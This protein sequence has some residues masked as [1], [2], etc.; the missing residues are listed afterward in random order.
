MGEHASPT[1]LYLS[2]MIEQSPL[3]TAVLDPDG[4]YLLVNSSW[5]ELWA[6]GVGGPSEEP[7]VFENERFMAMGL[8]PYLEACRRN[9]EI[10]TPLLFRE[11]TLAVWS[12]WLRAFIYPI[13]DE[14]G[15]LLRIGLVLEDFTE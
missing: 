8:T 12:R 13:R 15:G 11:A 1:D 9:G 4:R 6:L 7:N 14:A 5:K 10:T 2:T 3:A